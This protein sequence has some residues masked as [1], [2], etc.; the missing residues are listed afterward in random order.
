MHSL[1]NGMLVKLLLV[2]NLVIRLYGKWVNA[3][4]NT[5]DNTTF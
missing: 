5:V 4:V 1:A 2:I 3:L